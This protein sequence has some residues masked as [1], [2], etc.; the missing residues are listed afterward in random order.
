MI[1]VM[2]IKKMLGKNLLKKLLKSVDGEKVNNLLKKDLK[3]HKE[4]NMTIRK[5]TIEVK[6]IIGIIIE[7]TTETTEI[8]EQMV[9]NHLIEELNIKILLQ[10]QQN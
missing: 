5:M 6:E 9:V 7:E 4:T 8:T 10:Y 1:L 3:N 2:I